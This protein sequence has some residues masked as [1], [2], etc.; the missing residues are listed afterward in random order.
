MVLG[1]ALAFL[2]MQAAAPAAQ[3]APAPQPLT[4]AVLQA[5]VKASFD[6]LDANKDGW[7][8][9]A[10]AQKALDAAIADQVKR[11]TDYINQV[12]AKLDTNRD[13]S[14]SRAEFEASVP[15]PKAPATIPWM[16]GNDTNKDGR[17]SLIEA[18]NH[19]LAA[20]DRM[21]TNRNGVISADEARAAVQAAQ[22]K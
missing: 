8:D 2:M 9:R 10:E 11:R 13:G 12:F 20:F 4:K 17:V 21:D 1:S 3:A 14:I 15:V 6:R 18:T 5:Q 19:S 16:D 22:P 7:V